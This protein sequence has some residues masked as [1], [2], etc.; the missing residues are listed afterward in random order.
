MA[1]TNKLSKYCHSKRCKNSSSFL[2]GL[3]SLNVRS[4]PAVAYL[5]L[6]ENQADG[7]SRIRNAYCHDNLC[8]KDM[9]N[10]LAA[11]LDNSEKRKRRM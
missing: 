2:E 1:M 10:T 9:M 4:D 5:D 8:Q 11:Q 6:E 7:Y 3:N